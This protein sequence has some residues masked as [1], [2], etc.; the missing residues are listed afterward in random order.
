MQLLL[1]NER[2]GSRLI[3]TSSSSESHQQ[4][5]YSVPAP[6]VQ[7]IC[8]RS[9]LPSFNC[10]V[11]LTATKARQVDMSIQRLRR[12][13]RGAG[14]RD[15]LGRVE[16][17][18]EAA[19]PKRSAKRP[20]RAV[21]EEQCSGSSAV[22]AAQGYSVPKASTPTE[23]ISTSSYVQLQQRCHLVHRA[24]A[25]DM[26]PYAWTAPSRRA[27]GIETGWEALQPRLYQVFISMPTFVLFVRECV[28]RKACK[29]R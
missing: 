16:R 23:S 6:S 17:C 11:E 28:E 3:P 24:C 14:T 29:V 2:E 7:L 27:S 21:Q 13:H 20:A 22:G 1:W 25:Q 15:M 5:L 12:R 19:Y 9:M 18:K 26:A 8:Y 10:L 4:V